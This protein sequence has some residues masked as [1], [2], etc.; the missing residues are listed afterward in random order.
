VGI[1]LVVLGHV[2]DGVYRAGIPFPGDSFR[3][4][5]ESIYSFHM[6]L[7]FFLSGLFFIQSVER[8]G[9]GQFAANK[10]D[11]LMYPYFV[12]S[13][14]Q[15]LIEVAMSRYTNGAATLSD[16]LAIAWHP[17]MQLWFLYG[18]FFTFIV[19]AAAHRIQ[20]QSV[21]T[22]LPA[23]AFV[24]FLFRSHVPLVAPFQYL[25]LFSVFFLVGVAAA[26]FLGKPLS[27][28][29]RWWP[30]AVTVFLALET[31]HLAFLQRHET[32]AQAGL[33][34]ATA[35][36]GIASVISLCD[37]LADP[38][39]GL[40]QQLGRQSMVIFL[41]HTIAASGAR[42]LLQRG[43]GVGALSAHLVIGTTVG[44]V[45][46]MSLA[47]AARRYGLHALFTAPPWL[48]LEGR[49]LPFTGG[50]RPAGVHKP[51]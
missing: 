20:A 46:P 21:F 34:L 14:G 37:V 4:V 40:L 30:I 36:A 24:A 47:W 48:K 50:H 22:L 18:L 51:R 12:W 1:L 49:R 23:A 43:M 33:A 15:G 16:I 2:C 8:R 13:I 10:F 29:G 31:L 11:T 28:P 26:R 38:V 6:P 7:F 27:R 3:L 32:L 9:V 19:A 41:A 35:L 42:I 5:Y 39:Q 25:A 44:I 45:V 17:R